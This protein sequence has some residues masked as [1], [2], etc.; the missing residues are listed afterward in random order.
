MSNPIRELAKRFAFRYTRW[1]AP[2][3][4]YNI[5]PLQLAAIVNE[6]ERTAALEGAILEVG[7]AR[8]MTTRFICEHLLRTGR[9]TERLYAIDTF[10]S[11]NEDDVK[12]ETIVRGKSRQEL[13]AFD[14]NDFHT[15]SKNFAQFPFVT[16]VMAD[17]ATFDYSRI[18]PIKF[19]FLDVDL[20]RPTKEALGRIYAELCEGGVI[21]VDDVKSGINWDGSYQAYV[22]FCT[23]RGLPT[24]FLGSKCGVLRKDVPVRRE[25]TGDQACSAA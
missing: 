18:G 16:P 19:A 9:L 24:D 1:G 22:E 12:F 23:E 8:G 3:Y 10:S 4:P 13:V 2:R 14:Y 20:Y 17:C 11:F 25:A 15:W 21:L 7:V 5:E 6:L